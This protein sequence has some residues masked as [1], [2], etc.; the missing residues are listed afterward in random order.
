MPKR[1]ALVS[2]LAV[3]ALP[4]AAQANNLPSTAMAAAL[5]R[6]E[7]AGVPSPSIEASETTL[8]AVKAAAGGA[9]PKQA[10]AGLAEPAAPSFIVLH[11]GDPVTMVEMKGAFVL[12]MGRQPRGDRPPTGTYMTVGVQGGH[13]TYLQLGNAHHALPGN[14]LTVPVMASVAR[15]RTVRAHAAWWGKCNVSNHCYAQAAWPMYGGEG[16]V[17]AQG[18]HASEGMSVPY[19]SYG[20]F[21]GEAIWAGFPQAGEYWIE[22]GQTAGNGYDCCN[23][24]WYFAWQRKGLGYQEYVYPA[25]DRHAD[26]V[27]HPYD[28]FSEGNGAW[29]AQVDSIVVGCTSGLQT[30]AKSLAIGVETATESQPYNISRDETDAWWGGTRHYWNKQTIEVDGGQCWQQNPWF[31]HLGGIRSWTC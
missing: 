31:W 26:G 1:I 6:A 10:L 4:A 23:I 2:T 11:A 28:V 3:L 25:G 18:N 12:T 24:H 8:G 7:S 13:V 21:V 30:V 17:G 15:R 22:V 9:E 14:R 16:V 27:S 20:D 29:C 19:W 5:Q